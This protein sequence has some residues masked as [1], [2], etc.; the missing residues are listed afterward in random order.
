MSKFG[1]IINQAKSG[2]TGKPVIQKTSNTAS[3]QAS[4]PAK[5]KTSKP[6]IQKTGNTAS[7]NKGNMAS[8]KTGKAVNQKTGKPESG[9]SGLPENTVDDRS[10]NLTIKV[11]ETLRRHWSAEAKREGTSITAIVTE[12]LNDRF[13]KP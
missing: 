8:Q 3:Q 7:Q 12:A 13:G 6:E 2:E 11:P 10:V 4:K 5:Q 1:N 9:N